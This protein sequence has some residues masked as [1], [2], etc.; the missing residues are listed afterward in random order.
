MDALRAFREYIDFLDD[1]AF[2]AATTVKPKFT[3]HSDPSS[4]WIAARKGPTFFAYSN[5]QTQIAEQPVK[6]LQNIRP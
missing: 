1:A 4:Q 3:S 2:G 6:A 5:T